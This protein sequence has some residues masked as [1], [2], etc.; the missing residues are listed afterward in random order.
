MNALVCL[1]LALIVS[2]GP[3]HAGAGERGSVYPSENTSTVS[4][5][6]GMLDIPSWAVRVPE[7][8]FV[9]ISRPCSSIEGAR[10]QALDSAMGAEYYLSHESM[11][12]GD[13]NQSRYDLKEKLS[14]TARWLLNSVQQNV[15]EYAFRNTMTGNVC[16]ALVQMLPSELDN[17]KRLTIGAKLT[18][19][20]AGRTGEQATIEVTEANGVGATLIEYRISAETRYDH[21]RLITLFFW[22][23][24][25][26]E[27]RIFDGALATRLFVRN[28]LARGVITMSDDRNP[29]RSLIM[30]S[31]QDLSIT[32]TGYDEIG[33]PV[34]VP[35]R[36]Q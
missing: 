20:V 17:L 31:K 19:R 23:V 22:K 14:Y 10:Q 34:S 9:G 24:P 16:F 36:F 33:R 25:E 3:C 7:H 1:I 12:T 29:L 15:K 28:G 4:L 8:S 6:T 5:E 21:A 26:T 11:L 13:L 18:A 35:V 2:I 30:G 32:L 27:N